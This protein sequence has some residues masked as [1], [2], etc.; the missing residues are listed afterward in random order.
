VDQSLNHTQLVAGIADRLAAKVDRYLAVLGRLAAALSESHESQGTSV[1][2]LDSIGCAVLK[3]T[4]SCLL[5]E[6]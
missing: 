4:R 1:A 6:E 3:V 2:N 5:K